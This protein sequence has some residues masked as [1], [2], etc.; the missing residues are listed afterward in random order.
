MLGKITWF[1]GWKK[2]VRIDKAARDLATKHGNDNW[3]VI[4]YEDMASD[5][6]GTLRRVCEFSGISFESAMLKPQT[7]EFNGVGGNRLRKHPVKKI[8]LDEDW[9]KDM[10]KIILAFT[11]LSVRRFN[12]RYGYAPPWVF[13]LKNIF[14]AS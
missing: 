14:N 12:S 5:L 11:A 10:P 1:P 13:K 6:E 8:V 4:R 2:L 7:S 3:L 9:K